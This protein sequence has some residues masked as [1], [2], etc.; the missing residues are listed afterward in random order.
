M[1]RDR[2]SNLFFSLSKSN[3]DTVLSKS[4]EGCA[5]PKKSNLISLENINDD[6]SPNL[7]IL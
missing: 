2:L 7:Q 6:E 5:L 3:P 1:T 4:I